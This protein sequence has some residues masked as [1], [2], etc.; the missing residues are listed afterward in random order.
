MVTNAEIARRAFEIY[1]ERGRC[2]GHDFDDWLRAERECQTALTF[3][4]RPRLRV[5]T[6]RR[7]R[8]D[9]SPAFERRRSSA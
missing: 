4:S 9:S 5:K 8:R 1:C 2:H 3:D 7:E 6:D